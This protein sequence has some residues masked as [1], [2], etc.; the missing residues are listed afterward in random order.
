MW[1]L[2]VYLFSF[3]WN[4]LQSLVK[5]LY[6]FL[7]YNK[8]RE[9]PFLTYAGLLGDVTGEPKKNQ[10][11]A[12]LSELSSPIQTKAYDKPIFRLILP[13][14]VSDFKRTKQCISRNQIFLCFYL[15]LESWLL[16][17]LDRNLLSYKIPV[18]YMVH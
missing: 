4:L 11:L 13:H 15:L 14:W 2:C 16:P 1:F 9:Y 6:C 12:L 7:M 17:P 8:Q 5:N 10:E 18:F 3:L